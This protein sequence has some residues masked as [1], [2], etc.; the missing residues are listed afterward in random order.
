MFFLSYY[1]LL[2]FVLA[3]FLIFQDTFLIVFLFREP[4]WASVVAQLVKNLPPVQETRVQSL[5]WEDPL[6][7]EMALTPVSEKIFLI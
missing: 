6:E 1:C 2:C 5:G 3:F 4:L 7:K